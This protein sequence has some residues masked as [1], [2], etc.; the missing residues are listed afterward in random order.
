MTVTGRA[1][2]LCTATLPLLLKATVTGRADELCTATTPPL[3]S[4]DT[5]RPAAASRPAHDR[6]GALGWVP[7]AGY[8]VT[9]PPAAAPVTAT[10]STTALAPDAGTPPCPATGTVTVWPASTGTLATCS[11]ASGSKPPP[12]DPNGSESSAVSDDVVLL[13]GADV[14]LAEPAG[15]GPQAATEPAMTVPLATAPTSS[16]NRI[17]TPPLLTQPRARAER[18]ACR[19]D[20][21]RADLSGNVRTGSDASRSG[22][23]GAR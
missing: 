10:A 22:Q 21:R 23:H 19:M 11:P 2:E 1:E 5:A 6:L 15:C 14:A 20:G 13:A 7:S 4:A 18:S 17:S 8:T 12:T 3:L 16:R 9:L